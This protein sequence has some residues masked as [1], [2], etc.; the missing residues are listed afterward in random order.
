[1]VPKWLNKQNMCLKTVRYKDLTENDK[2]PVSSE[3]L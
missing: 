1:M 3:T 2:Q